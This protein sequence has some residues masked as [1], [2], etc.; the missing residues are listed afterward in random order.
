MYVLLLRYL[1]TQ[2]GRRS[3]R[4]RK[5]P[6]AIYDT[7]LESLTVPQSLSSKKGSKLNA[8]RGKKR[9]VKTS[10]PGTDDEISGEE[11]EED[12]EE[13][14]EDAAEESR[15]KN[16]ATVRKNGSNAN[17][18]AKGTTERMV[19]QANARNDGATICKAITKGKSALQLLATSWVN[20]FGRNG[21]VAMVDMV[22]LVVC[23]TGA[24]RNALTGDNEDLSLVDADGDEWK[25][26]LEEIQATLEDGLSA[27]GGAAVEHRYPLVNGHRLRRNMPEWWH[28]VVAECRHGNAYN[29]AL[30]DGVVT[31]LQV[32]TSSN[33]V[34]LRHTATAAVYDI[35]DALVSAAGELMEKRAVAERQLEAEVKK[36]SKNSPKAKELQGNV[37]ALTDSNKSLDEVINKA[38]EG[39][40]VLRHKDTQTILRQES[41]EALGRWL[42]K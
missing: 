31:V 28:A 19:T 11:E 17:K 41:M 16:K 18:N 27:K 12:D 40:W 22:N 15:K 7:S 37:S 32:L 25:A 21:P 13:D 42:I 2:M 3:A 26:I 36:A 35:M 5:A 1:F 38:F 20:W 10:S 30:L 8:S 9:T 34:A 6:K 4:D 14:D 39:V 29:Y 24:Q 33:I 23:L